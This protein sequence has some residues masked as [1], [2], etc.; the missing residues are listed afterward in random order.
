MEPAADVE[1]ERRDGVAQ[2]ERA[3]HRSAGTVEGGE[4][5]EH[6]RLER[7]LVV[8]VDELE[9]AGVERQRPEPVAHGRNAADRLGP[10]RGRGGRPG[11]AGHLL[12]EHV[13]GAHITSTL[14][15]TPLVSTSN[16]ADRAT[17]C[18]TRPR[19][20]SAGASPSTSNAIEMRS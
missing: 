10:R 18:S 14:T 12:G 13:E 3:A 8:P 20:T 19:G 11:G 4:D 17:D 5:P 7:D 16:T 1:P 2:A 6:L 15:G 9:G